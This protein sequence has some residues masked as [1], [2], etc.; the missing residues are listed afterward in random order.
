MYPKGYHPVRLDKSLDFGGKPQYYTR[1]QRPPRYYITGFGP[2][3]QY[4]SRRVWDYPHRYGDESVPEIRH[5]RT[6]NPFHTDIY[7][8]GNIVRGC[9][10]RVRL[11]RS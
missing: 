1:T 9:F 2:S 11:V 3:R 7:D 10:L 8:L 5:G 4:T 6:C